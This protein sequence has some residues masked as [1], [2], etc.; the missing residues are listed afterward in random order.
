MTKP[1]DSNPTSKI[2]A[3]KADSVIIECKPPE[4]IA[5]YL[6]LNAGQS[7]EWI[8]IEKGGERWVDLRRIIE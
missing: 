2:R 4:R 3:A 7:V 8:T 1:K 6:S 5:G